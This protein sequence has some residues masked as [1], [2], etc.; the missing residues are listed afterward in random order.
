MLAEH[1]AGDWKHSYLSMDL[2]VTANTLLKQQFQKYIILS[3]KKHYTVTGQAYDPLS[4]SIL[5]ITLSDI[6]NFYIGNLNFTGCG[7]N[8]IRIRT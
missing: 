7:I 5:Q 4:K 2:K 6:R 1:K 3:I 8:M